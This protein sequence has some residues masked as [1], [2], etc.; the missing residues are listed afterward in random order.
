MPFFEWNLRRSDVP[1]HREIKNSLPRL[2]EFILNIAKNRGIDT[3]QSMMEFANPQVLSL[4]SPF[5]LSDIDKGVDRIQKAIEN[6]EKILIFGDKDADGVTA[7]AIIYRIV[8]RFH[9]DISFRV[10]EGDEHYGI[11]VNALNEAKAQGVTLVITVD[12][13]IT[14]VDECIYAKELGIDIVITDH[15]EP[16]EVL[17]VALAMINPKLHNYPFPSL[18]GA[19]VAFKL[20]HA[21]SE[22]Y[23]LPEYNREYI[24]FDIETTGLNPEQDDIIEIAAIRFKNGLALEEFQTLILTDKEIS[25]EVTS[26]TNI[27][28][29]MVQEEGIPINDALEQFLEFIGDRDLVGHNI[30]G[31]D[32]KFMSNKLKK[33]LKTTISNTP[34]DTLPL[35]RVLFKHL[36][37]FTLYDVAIHLGIY[38]DQSSL[39]RALNDVSLNTEVFRRMVLSRS[40]PILQ[41]LSE[42]LPLAAIGTV[43]DI[44]P[45]QGENRIIVRMG[46]DPE[47]IKLTTT[48]LLSLLR[49]LNIVD[50]IN[51]K[52]I[53]WTLG[54]IINSPG[55]LGQASLV[56]DL[57]TATHI[58]KANELTE[59]LIKKDQE[60][61]NLITSLEEEIVS[62]T[63]L[64]EI[65]EK[66]HVFIM[67]Q[68]ISRGITGLIATRLTNQ[69]QV[70]VIIVA[71]SNEETVSGS[72]R[73][74]GSF[75]VVECLQSMSNLFVRFGGHKAAGGFVI[76]QNKIDQFKTALSSYME[77]WTSANLRN[78]LDIDIELTDLTLL[79]IKNIHYI[80]SLFDPIGSKNPFPNFLVKGVTLVGERYIGKNKEHMILRFLKGKTEFN[81]IAW[82]FAKRWQEVKSH[83]KFDIVGIPEINTWNDTQEVR[84]QLIDIDG[85]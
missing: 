60:R 76:P 3:Y 75:D 52:A 58:N 20:A 69:F 84:L 36:K 17:P 32:L 55:R 4:P 59:E 25:A 66:K 64:N 63:N 56:V 21:L 51:A 80:Q 81:V 43:A 74:T 26:I 13:G 54:P 27:T 70:P 37:S 68:N 39:H 40:R 44:M 11:S 7:T 8:T 45:L 61:K 77:N 23:L 33:H 22:A 15:H 10:P 46:T 2:P 73:S 41:I 18:A 5:A 79:S 85:K 35:A 71:L 29:K 6:K 28:N 53:G 14:A 83:Q 16:L 82:G 9:G 12:C 31:F 34:I 72:V 48:G 78:P 62:S 57:L 67:S 24:C 65:I 38:I 19:G 1:L 49:R 47:N 50:T 30:I 42:L